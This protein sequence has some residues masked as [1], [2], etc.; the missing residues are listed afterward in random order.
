MGPQPEH[1]GFGLRLDDTC[2]LGPAGQVQCWSFQGAHFL[3]QVSNRILG[4]ST[5]QRRQVDLQAQL[6]TT[7]LGGRN[8]SL[9]FRH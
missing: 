7:R 5:A 2:G 8:R 6:Q 4:V 9:L 3:L 1:R